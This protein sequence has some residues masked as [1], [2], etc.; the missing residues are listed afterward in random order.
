MDHDT[1]ILQS[2]NGYFADQ[3]YFTY[4][5]LHTVILNTAVDPLILSYLNESRESIS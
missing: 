3:L 2:N 1:V 4:C 5:E